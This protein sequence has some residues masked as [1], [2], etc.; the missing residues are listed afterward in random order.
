[1]Y[2]NHFNDIVYVFFKFLLYLLYWR[3]TVAFIVF[4]NLISLLCFVPVVYIL[5]RPCA[6][7][8][9]ALSKWCRLPYDIVD[10]SS[11]YLHSNALLKILIPPSSSVFQS[12]PTAY[13]MTYIVYKPVVDVAR[14]AQCCVHTR[15]SSYRGQTHRWTDGQTLCDNKVACASRANK[16]TISYGGLFQILVSN[17]RFLYC[18][19]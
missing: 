6:T 15:D 1:M 16:M 8:E 5:R 2:N 9:G 19:F 17:C 12:L 10:F 14:D 13:K 4:L 18:C 3:C 7:D 11:L